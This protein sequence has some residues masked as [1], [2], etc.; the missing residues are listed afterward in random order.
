MNGD[1]NFCAS[2]FILVEAQ[3]TADYLLISVNRDLDTTSLSIALGLLSCDPPFS[4]NTPKMLVALGGIGL[5]GLAWNGSGAGRHDNQRVGI[6][7]GY[8]SVEALIVGTVA[9]ERGKRCVQLIEYGPT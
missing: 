9:G 3:P 8:G 7:F 6:P 1:T 5:S 4:S 2:A